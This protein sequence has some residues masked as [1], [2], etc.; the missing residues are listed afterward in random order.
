MFANT[1]LQA[2]ACVFLAEPGRTFSGS[3]YYNFHFK[4][5]PRGN[6]GTVEGADHD[7]DGD[8]DDDGGLG[9]GEREG[10][11]V[12]RKRTRMLRAHRGETCGPTGRLGKRCRGRDTELRPTGPG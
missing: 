6:E 11:V 5:C 9:E 3:S 10:W 8:D 7:D 1:R 2:E 4:S 12:A